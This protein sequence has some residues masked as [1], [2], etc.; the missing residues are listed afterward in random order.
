[1]LA[2]LP[3][4]YVLHWVC[5]WCECALA[6]LHKTLQVKVHQTCWRSVT[7]AKDETITFGNRSGG[8]LNSVLSCVF[9]SIFITVLSPKMTADLPQ[10]ASDTLLME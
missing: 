8:G 1:M 3:R 4:R 5:L 10:R 9:V 2:T 7:R 6:A